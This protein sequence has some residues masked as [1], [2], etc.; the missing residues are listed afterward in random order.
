[1]ANSELPASCR[2]T[3]RAA[4]PALVTCIVALWS[5]IAMAT[6]TQGDFSIFGSL[7]TRWSGR[8]GEGS[9]RGGTPSTT[10]GAAPP[11][12]SVLAPGTPAGETGGSF[13]FNHWD[14]VQ[15]R[16]VVDIRPDYHLV[17]NYKLLGR[18]DTLLLHDAD[19]FAIYKGW[20]DA[21]PDLKPKGRA[22]TGRD[23]GNFTNA[24]RIDEFT[25]DEL[26][27]Y[28]AQLNFTDNFSMRIGKQQV[29]WT[30]ADALSGSELTNPNDFRIHFINFE[31][32]EDT[33]VNLR[34]VKFNYIFPDFLKTAD[35]GLEAFWIPGDFQGSVNG[36]LKADTTDARN[37]WIVPV[38]FPSASFN[39]E[40]QPFRMATLMDQGAKPMI[41]LFPTFPGFLDAHIIQSQTRMSNSIDNSEFGMRYSTLLPIGNGLQTNLIYLY[42]AR[43]PKVAQLCANC[44]NP[45][46]AEFVQYAPGIFISAVGNLPPGA[47]T[48]VFDWG[49]PQIAN[50]FG[51]VRVLLRTEHV[52]Q[53]FLGVTGTYYDKDLTDIVY[54]YDVT[55]SPKEASGIG[56]LGGAGLG[57]A[58]LGGVNGQLAVTGGPQHWGTTTAWIVSG[59]R[60]TYIPWISKQHTFLTA[61]Y[62]ADW[63]PDPRD[64]SRALDSLFFIAATNWLY[65]GQWTALN[66][67]TWSPDEN[68]GYL[69]SIN[70]FRYSRDILFGIN[71][72]WYLGRSGLDSP[73]FGSVL[74]RS[75]RINEIEFRLTY[76]I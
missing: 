28:Y 58:G 51:T 55:Y 9:A 20:Y 24:D 61:Q 8:W 54:R 44:P 56:G 2:R 14:L 16:Q 46:P 26:R 42:E 39:Q 18:L 27:E 15:A 37:P 40:G 34:M 32:A 36:S 65:N 7:A 10:D 43:S 48:P 76:E 59:D 12:T 4:L 13:D 60:P 57:G 21:F 29:I 19:F 30:E 31:A 11:N 53:N 68:V 71:A 1:M 23:W 5:T 49:P 62:T 74:S 35:N 50:N 6:I 72:V 73:G 52:R 69:S 45:D 25:K 70:T 38:A 63:T 66:V 47:T 41:S 3:S 17:K 75:Q 22:E 33:R 67:F 64:D